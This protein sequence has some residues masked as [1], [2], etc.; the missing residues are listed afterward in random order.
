MGETNQ[1]MPVERP[2]TGESSHLMGAAVPCPGCQS[3]AI[4]SSKYCGQCG[5]RLWEPCLACGDVNSVAERFCGGCG[6]DLAGTVA[7]A[8]GQANRQLA[9][10]ERLAE[11]GRLIDAVRVLEATALA[12]HSQFSELRST[13][14]ERIEKYRSDRERV[15]HESTAVL[16]EVKRLIALPDYRAALA[17]AEK[18]PPALRNS[19]LTQLHQTCTAKVERI[20]ELSEALTAGVQQKAY[21]GLVATARQLTELDPA[22]PDAQRLFQ[23]LTA[24]QAKA[25]AKRDAQ[26]LK[27]AEAALA[28]NAY[29]RA[30]GLLA[31]IDQDTWQRPA[32]IEK[33]YRLARERVWAANFVGRAPY[34]TSD[35]VAAA[36]RLVKLQPGDPAAKKLAMQLSE[37]YKK[38]AGGPMPA[39]WAKPGEGS[40]VGGTVELC[41]PPVPL[42]QACSARKLPARDFVIAYGLALQA[43]GAADVPLNLM[44]SAKGGWRDKLKLAGGGRSKQSSWGIDLGGGSLKA[45]CLAP[46]TEADSPV[47]Q[48]VL[49]IVY[50]RDV[51]SGPA[52][53]EGGLPAS[54]LEALGQLAT[55][56]DLTRSPVALSLSG[57]QTL[58]R[59]F[60]LPVPSAAKFQQAVEYEAAARVP[61][62]AENVVYDFH[63]HDL[64]TDEGETPRRW[65]TLVA[66]NRHHVLRRTDSLAELG[67]KQLQVVSSTVALVNASLSAGGAIAPR[68]DLEGAVALVDVGGSTSN[69]AILSSDKLWMRG[70]FIGG[71][72]MSQAI[73]KHLK[74]DRRTAGATRQRPDQAP[75]MHQVAES[76]EGVFEELADQLR[77]TFEQARVDLGVDVGRVLLTG[78]ESYAFGLV[79]SL[80]LGDER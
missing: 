57:P 4:K 1:T 63:A 27:A 80:R 61:L 67:I 53:R 58:G 76:L 36:A 30:E 29:R 70:L 78:S 15:I 34:A 69:V 6:G 38:A 19:E 32:E 44:P 7:E 59:F 5:T 75:W 42:A 54:V 52:S 22:D 41:P 10:A 48:E 62:P 43:A 46:S 17:E 28:E 14:N 37:R 56:F 65:V 33:R 12:E 25:D 74:V 24:W 45:V 31:R 73:A 64:P 71:D 60:T 8:E 11:F 26:H 51:D 47:V 9:E 39:T 66:A 68:G 79:R 50:D 3:P 23:Q 49:S 77:R 35:V 55:N 18:I 40:A 16:E 20:A 72:T 21:D 13:I 2:T